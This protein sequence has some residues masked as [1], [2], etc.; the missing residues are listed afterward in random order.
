[1]GAKAARREVAVYKPSESTVAEKDPEA[2]KQSTNTETSNGGTRRSRRLL[3]QQ[4]EQPRP[5]S[6]QSVLSKL[7][8]VGASP[9]KIF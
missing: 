1:L 5:E 9:S 7:S 2:E 4:R 8:G 6:K 3:E